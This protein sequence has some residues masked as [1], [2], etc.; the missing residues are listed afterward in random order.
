MN[1]VQQ[2]APRIT[3]GPHAGQPRPSSEILLN[4]LRAAMAAVIVLKRNGHNA[5]D[6]DH[7][8]GLTPRIWIENCARC[9]ELADAYT[10]K[11]AIDQAGAYQVKEIKL[12]AVRVCWTVRGH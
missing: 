5:I 7:M 6:I 2:H 11:W 10:V 1:A 12:D 9:A 3:H 4:R 8:N